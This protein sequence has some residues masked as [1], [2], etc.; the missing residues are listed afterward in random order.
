MTRMKNLWC[1]SVTFIGGA[2]SATC[3][4]W[5]R[6]NST[7]FTVRETLSFFS[8]TKRFF[9]VRHDFLP[10]TT[11]KRHVWYPKIFKTTWFPTSFK[12][13]IFLG[14]GVKRSFLLTNNLLIRKIY[15][16]ITFLLTSH[17]ICKFQP[18]IY[19]KNQDHW[20]QR[21]NTVIAV[22]VIFFVVGSTTYQPWLYWPT[23]WNSDYVQLDLIN[24]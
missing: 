5:T 15:E 19:T 22:K 21:Y 1:K 7:D 4:N 11:S 10:K 6:I 20:T 3:K 17:Q 14:V 9:S 16:K 18:S 2:E 13:L 12:P 23:L 24:V 8:V